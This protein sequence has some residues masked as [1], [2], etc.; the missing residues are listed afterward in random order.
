MSIVTATKKAETAWSNLATKQKSAIE[1]IKSG[2][3]TN[4]EYLESLNS[5]ASDVKDIFGGASA[6]TSDFVAAHIDD[7][8]KMAQGDEEAAERVEDAWR[9]AQAELDGWDHQKTV[10]I[11]VN[12]DGFINELDT[13]DVLLD[14]YFDQWNDKEIGFELTADDTQAI[15]ALQ[16]LIDSGDITADGINEALAG[17]GWEPEIEWVP[18]DMPYEDVVRLYGH[19]YDASGNVVDVE[20]EVFN[21]NKMTAFI[22]KIK[23]YLAHIASSFVSI[24]KFPP[25]IDKSLLER[26]AS[27]ATFILKYPE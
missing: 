13:L 15:E 23:S 24:T 5:V 11:D 10:T 4:L 16:N 21:E 26:K 2:D 14:D 7:I 9:Q 17:I 25:R 20:E 1:L 3:K 18:T 19:I 8:E 12:Q 27:S 22:P 6:I